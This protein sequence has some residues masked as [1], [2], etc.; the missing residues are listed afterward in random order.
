MKAMLGCVVYSGLKVRQPRFTNI[1]SCNNDLVLL[2]ICLVRK[3]ADF[4]AMTCCLIKMEMFVNDVFL[5]CL[6]K[7]KSHLNKNH[8]YFFNNK[9]IQM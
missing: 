6:L 3:S 5:H 7:I 8:F 9:A 2:K 1:I 4:K